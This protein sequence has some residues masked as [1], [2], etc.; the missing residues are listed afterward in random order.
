M[1]TYILRERVHLLNLIAFL[2][3]NWEQASADGHP[4][5]VETRPENAKRSNA[6]NRCYWDMLHQIE[7][8]AWL[9]GRR[10]TADVW[11][12]HF[13]RMFIGILELPNGATMGQTTTTLTVK[14]FSEYIDQVSEYAGR[15]LGVVF[16]DN[17]Y[18]DWR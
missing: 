3:N 1:K 18:N 7:E 11:H 6:Q 15:V 5:V 12:E 14:Q 13:R 10:F 8:E 2:E 9:D 17:N 16:E 4:L